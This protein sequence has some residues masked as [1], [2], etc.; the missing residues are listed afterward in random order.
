[1]IQARRSLEEGVK[2]EASP[3]SREDMALR[4]SRR[5]QYCEV[6]AG[7]SQSVLHMVVSQLA[8]C[9]WGNLERTGGVA[10]QVQQVQEL[11]D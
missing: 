1:M 9:H 2:C 5:T 7:D 8:L 6:V 10:Q 3:P 11:S 4:A